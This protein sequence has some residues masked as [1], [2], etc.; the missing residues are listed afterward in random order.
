MVKKITDHKVRCF[1]AVKAPLITLLARIKKRITLEN[2]VPPDNRKL[3]AIQPQRREPIPS[4][5][6][7]VISNDG[8]KA[9][10]RLSLARARGKKETE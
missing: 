5:S 7:S 10:L 1:T 8:Q 4:L 9:T 2:F 3:F 6:L